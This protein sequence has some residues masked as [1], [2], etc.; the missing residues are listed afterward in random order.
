MS[1]IIKSKVPSAKSEVP[2][3]SLID[4]NLVVV[5]VAD[6]VDTDVVRQ[7]M[8]QQVMSGGANLGIQFPK[9]TVL[10][11][12]HCGGERNKARVKAEDCY[13]G[14]PPE[15]VK[16][17]YRC[18]EVDR[19]FNW[20]SDAGLMAI[21]SKISAS[22][23]EGSK[24]E[25]NIFCQSDVDFDEPDTIRTLLNLRDRAKHSGNHVMVIA[26]GVEQP[27]NVAPK[28]GPLCDEVV[29]AKYCAPDPD[30]HQ[31][32]EIVV[33]DLRRSH[34]FGVGRIMASVLRTTEN[35]KIRYEPFIHGGLAFRFAWRLSSAGRSLEDVGKVLNKNKST[36]MRWLRKLPPTT[37]IKFGEAEINKTL[38][39]IECLESESDVDDDELPRATAA[40]RKAKGKEI[41]AEDD[42]ELDL[43]DEDE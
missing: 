42:D 25:W 26:G 37:Q 19:R 2:P 15:G 3:S 38:A 9:V 23:A 39:M 41:P 1:K 24:G 14:Q 21:G 12:W 11:S 8:M 28:L 16:R 27:D 32:I 13:Y 43:L 17:I 36:I 22:G 33:P 10:R 6:H 18:L 30:V 31:A 29:L 20:L 5:L 35:F 40:D 34:Q 7:L 4:M